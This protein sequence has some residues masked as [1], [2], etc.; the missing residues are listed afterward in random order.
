MRLGVPIMISSLHSWVKRREHP[1]ADLIYRAAKGFNKV[2]FPVV[3]PI[4]RPL[5][6]LRNLVLHG[7]HEVRRIFWWTP[8]FQSRLERPAPGLFVFTGIPQIIGP[9]AVE[10]GPNC[11]ISGHTTLLGRAA[12]A[13]RPRLTIGRNSEIGW[14]T[15]IAVGRNVTIGDNVLVAGRCFL[16]GY[17]GHPQD[18][19]KR[20]AHMPDTDDQVGDIILEDDVWLATDVV[21]MAGVRIGRGTIVTAGSVVFRD[22]P[23]GVIA[24][25]N[26]ARPVGVVATASAPTAEASVKAAPAPRTPVPE[27]AAGR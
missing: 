11:S 3:R 27:T 20:A 1:L 4:H 19:V 13:T 25:G 10:F 17:P 16:A 12:G 18:P 24:T 2:Q 26:P 22:L 21:V 9:L 5:Y 15:T 7:I 23:P 6:H 8:L 14:Q